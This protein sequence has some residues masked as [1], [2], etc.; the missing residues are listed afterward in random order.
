M[1]NDKFQ[2]VV[3]RGRDIANGANRVV[4]VGRDIVNDILNNP[5]TRRLINHFKTLPVETASK[6]NPR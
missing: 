5:E 1:R 3:D 6:Y 4:G 2:T